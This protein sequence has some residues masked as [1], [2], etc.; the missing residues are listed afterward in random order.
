MN[1]V[2]RMT[3]K[4]IILGGIAIVIIVIVVILIQTQGNKRNMTKNEPTVSSTEIE[5][6]LSKGQSEEN[7]GVKEKTTDSKGKE[8][9]VIEA[10]DSIGKK[11]N[12]R[13]EAVID[14][15]GLF[16]KETNNKKKVDTTKK[17]TNDKNTTKKKN[18]KNGDMEN[19]NKETKVIQNNNDDGEWSDFY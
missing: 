17:T 4:R 16:E 10:E 18:I 9:E 6:T 14:A 2:I 5:T 1:E 3:K 19:D 12:Q 15:S 11:K 7:T 13:E 8:I